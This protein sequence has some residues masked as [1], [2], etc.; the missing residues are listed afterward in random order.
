MGSKAVHEI[1]LP[2]I[3]AWIV[4]R[5]L[6]RFDAGGKCVH[7]ALMSAER[8]EAFVILRHEMRD[9]E[10]WDLMI[11]HGEALRTWRLPV[12]GVPTGDHPVPVERIG[13]H[14]LAYLDYEGPISG[15]RGHVWRLD[16]GKARW[17]NDDPPSMR[18]ELRGKVFNGIFQISDEP[19]GGG[20]S[21]LHM[22]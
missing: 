19:D 4:P 13:D 6:S 18:V 3:F 8:T 15:G 20:R 17:I 9:G 2:L 22:T 14:R 16:R 11:Q 10:H 12:G 5:A 21:R 7:D 1:D